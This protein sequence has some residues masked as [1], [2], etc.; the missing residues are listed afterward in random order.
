M[1]L[2]LV[3]SG[4]IIL[5]Y[6]SCCEALTEA[7][8]SLE[9]SNQYGTVI[10][11]HYVNLINP[12]GALGFEIAFGGNEFRLNTT[13]ANKVASR[14]QFKLTVDYLSQ[15]RPYSI[16]I[17][18][19]R[20]WGIQYSVAEGY[21]YLIPR[22][23]IASVNVSAYQLHSNDSVL[24]PVYQV[25]D[26]I[27]ALYRNLRGAEGY[28]GSLGITVSPF[29]QTRINLDTLYDSVIFRNQFQP[30]PDKK[31]FGL[32][33]QINQV[34]HPRFALNIDATHRAV[35][36]SYAGS[37]QWILP[38][39]MHNT[40]ALSIGCQWVNGRAPILQDRRLS[41][42]LIYQGNRCCRNSQRWVLDNDIVLDAANPFVRMPQTLMTLDQQIIANNF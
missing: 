37:L 35:Y 21:S 4:F 6:S 16:I 33:V 17:G 36:D 14:H 3:L 41:L 20:V 26:L 39:I 10:D 18:P 2:I 40:L 13:L 29:D 5:S 15:L 27:L 22:S 8:A 28:G 30:A 31:G 19:T 9:Q 23:K 11:S 34:L 32:C 24:A 1:R 42:T 38:K 25:N 12:C 7:W